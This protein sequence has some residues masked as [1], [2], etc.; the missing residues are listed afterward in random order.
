[1][2]LGTLGIFIELLSPGLVGP[3]VLGVIALALAFVALGNLPV[4]WVG[5]QQF[6]VNESGM[7]AR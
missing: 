2:S 3:G 4:N 5:V 6:S 1:M 7:D